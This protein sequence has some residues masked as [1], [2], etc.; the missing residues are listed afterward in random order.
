MTNQKAL[1]TLT[2]LNPAQL[3]PTQRR[4]HL[5]PSRR[6]VQIGRASKSL[7]KGLV[8]SV[9]NAWF[10]SPV[11][12][13]NH[14][15]ILLHSDNK[16]LQLQDIGSMHGTILNDE[17]LQRKEPRSLTS[18]D[19]V[20]FG[21]EVRRGSETFPACSF[22][23]EYEFSPHES[24]VMGKTI[25]APESS[26]IE[27]EVNDT[28]D[29]DMS[30]FAV[31]S[32]DDVHED[33]STDSPVSKRSTSV[34]IVGEFSG[35]KGLSEVQA[36]EDMMNMK[37][38]PKTAG[39]AEDPVVIESDDDQ[40][41][42]E[43]MDE[44]ISDNSGEHSD[45][46]DDSDIV[47]S[48]QP[49]PVPLFHSELEL[50]SESES[51]A[52]AEASPEVVLEEVRRLSDNQGIE[53]SDVRTKDN[54][55]ALSSDSSPVNFKKLPKKHLWAEA[56]EAEDVSGDSD[57]SDDF[58]D[59]EISKAPTKATNGPGRSLIESDV[60]S[61]PVDDS[62][63]SDSSSDDDSVESVM[64][65]TV[66]AYQASEPESKAAEEFEVE[67]SFDEDSEMD[68][69]ASSEK[70]S[71]YEIMK[72]ALAPENEQE[73]SPSNPTPT[74]PT[75]P[76]IAPWHTD[77]PAGSFNQEKSPPQPTT[78]GETAEKASLGR[79]P[80]PSDAAMVKEDT[81]PVAT[82]MATASTPAHGQPN[83]VPLPAV[84]NWLPYSESLDFAQS[85]G[86]K[87]G[88]PAFFQAR[89]E[90]RASVAA[91]AEVAGDAKRIP[92]QTFMSSSVPGPSWACPSSIMPPASYLSS[93]PDQIQPQKRTY[94]SALL[95]TQELRQ[96]SQE[97]QQRAHEQQQHQHVLQAQEQM[98][99]AQEHNRR[100]QEHNREVAHF[101]MRENAQRLRGNM[102]YS[103]GVSTTPAPDMI[104]ATSSNV[105]KIG[106][107]PKSVASFH[108][109]TLVNRPESHAPSQ[110]PVESR[111]R[112]ADAISELSGSEGI[113]AIKDDTNEADIQVVQVVPSVSGETTSTSTQ[114]TP[115]PLS[116]PEESAVR[117]PKRMKRFA[118]AVGYAALG[119]AAVGA[120]L[121]SVLVATAP[122]FL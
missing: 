71:K 30:D 15:E 12:S 117:A 108:N 69:T 72:K 52:E 4:L 68:V 104:N 34:E 81:A 75:L 110:S 106:T 60:E 29:E 78:S 31:S 91:R 54:H 95:H 2:A 112:K 9:D 33:I 101:R 102:L 24:A 119:G 37:K 53:I 36:L 76:W 16:T 73:A 25:Q 14:A 3:F 49:F 46:D 66:M 87:T 70:I 113:S 80:S 42:D 82:G 20:K 47:I 109:F 115:V 121:F 92:D 83:P 27:D 99:R 86:E 21:A 120:G 59:C 88:K 13:R 111:K 63:D 85:M 18:G 26:D 79:E 94:E 57:F 58:S 19:V 90:N 11:M 35:P 32:N 7:N 107:S 28:D 17:E 116:T 48:S 50:E 38:S 22:K 103:E 51:E 97:M 105:S 118:E 67:P 43:E 89:M 61:E 8:A 10:D 5:N 64:G 55:S 96:R 41:T 1:V 98:R 84:K 45:S 56:S 93:L 114:S 65:D 23:V 39:N 77:E 40:Q 44:E 100:A 62:E 74:L 122:D 6:T